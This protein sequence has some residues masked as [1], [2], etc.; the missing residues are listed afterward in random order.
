MQVKINQVIPINDL[1]LSEK[2]VTCLCFQVSKNILHK[3]IA[4]QK[5][6]KYNAKIRQ[7]T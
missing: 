5:L 4:C 6:L 3:V 7:P 2:M 1:V